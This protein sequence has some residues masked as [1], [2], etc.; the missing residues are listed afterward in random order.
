MTASKT[1]NLDAAKRGW[2]VSVYLNRFNIDEV[3]EIVKE[4]KPGVNLNLYIEIGDVKDPPTEGT[5]RGYTQMRTVE[6]D[7]VAKAIP[8]GVNVTLYQVQPKDGLLEGMGTIL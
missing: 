5:N 7:N 6:Y 2:G 1:L 4:L 3:I 8:T